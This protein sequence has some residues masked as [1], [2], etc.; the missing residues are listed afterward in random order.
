MIKSMTGFGRGEFRDKLYHFSVEIKT[1]NHRYNDIIIKIPR[2]ISFL[3]EKINK[4]IKDK[5]SRGRIEVYIYFEYLEELDV[6]IRTDINL[7]KSYLK[8]LKKLNEK[9]D[10]KDKITLSHILNNEEVI[11]TEKQELGEDE[12][13]P[14]LSKAL[15]DALDNVISMRIEEGKKLLKDIESGLESIKEKIKEIEKRSPLVVDEY[16]VKL[17]ERIKELLNGKYSLDEDR[18]MNEVAIFADKS[19]INEE[20]VRLYSH[21]SHFTK[22]LKENNPVGRKLDFLIQEMNREVNTIGAKANDTEISKNVVKIKSELEKI[23]EQIQ[24]VE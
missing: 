13:W 5:I 23:R 4:T 16:K 7:A 21:I 3:E 8:A 22:I 19:D 20:I 24:N 10:I 2:H 9:L 14:S 11:K 15:N 6:G 12:L 17:E 18:L 1:L